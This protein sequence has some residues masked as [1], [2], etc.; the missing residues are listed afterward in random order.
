MVDA[1]VPRR[2]FVSY[3]RADAEVAT[4]IAAGLRRAGH[5]VTI[6]A[7]DF[8]PGNNFVI[9]MQQGLTTADHVL[10]VLSPAYEQSPFATAEW[11]AAFAADPLG[12]ERRLIGVRVEDYQPAGLL[13]PIIY[14]DIVGRSNDEADALITAAIAS[15]QP[16][17]P[18]TVPLTGSVRASQV[19]GAPSVVPHFSGRRDALAAISVGLADGGRL[20]VTG[21]GGIGKTSLVST[22]VHE[23]HTDFDLVLWLYAPNR[24]RALEAVAVVVREL[25]LVDDHVDPELAEAALRGHLAGV[26]RALVVLDDCRDAETASSLILDADSNVLVTSRDDRG[27]R[28]AG[29]AQHRLDV[30]DRNEAIE[31]V[32][33][34]APEGG[35]GADLVVDALEGL[36]LALA[37]A[38]AY[39]DRDAISFTDFMDRLA[40]YAPQVFEQPPG[41]HYT[42][43]VLSTWSL[44]LDDLQSADPAAA[45]ILNLLAFVDP[46]DFP[47]GVLVAGADALP[48]TIAAVARD[49]FM[50]D[51][52]IALLLRQSLCR[53]DGDGLSVHPVIQ[54]VVKSRLTESETEL[55]IRSA[56]VMLRRS[57]PEDDDAETWSTWERLAAHTVVA[58][59]DLAARGIYSPDFVPLVV[60]VA[61]FSSRRGFPHYANYL[62][63]QAIGYVTAHADQAVGSDALFVMEELAHSF[64][65]LRAADR[66]VSLLRSLIEFSQQHGQQVS[67]GAI[68]ARVGLASALTDTGD[69][70]EALRE[71]ELAAQAF[72]EW[73]EPDLSLGGRLY[74]TWGRLLVRTGS[75]AEG[76]DRLQR[77][78]LLAEEAGSDDDLALTHLH[79]GNSYRGVAGCADARRHYECARDIAMQLPDRPQLHA[80]IL[81]NLSGVAFESGDRSLALEHTETALRILGDVPEGLYSVTAAMIRYQR[82]QFRA[83]MPGVSVMEVLA[84]AGLAFDI[85][86][87]H[88]PAG[89]P[90]RHQIGGFLLSIA[91]ALDDDSIRELVWER[92]PGLRAE[93]GP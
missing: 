66:A 14:V 76:R 5:E 2:L 50:L 93:P 16:T 90:H 52:A 3:T 69:H 30:L 45:W 60:D 21:F 46:N 71:L 36:P 48:E 12:T 72:E 25:G 92:E 34:A 89:H 32:L 10:A 24:Q 91:E 51:A 13:G 42:H 81:V 83:R 53:A 64:L 31:F 7:A 27:W 17:T 49:P 33:S 11:A 4:R 61:R 79:L 39:V 62:Y 57:L 35:D 1:P 68:A 20:A 84:D 28:P 82:A 88:L 44:A 41:H 87:D 73:A 55:T 40:T 67:R 63:T 19:R 56:V 26:G 18:V 8:R 38:A 29:F 43:T 65:E 75:P 37:Q 6:Q 23:H 77:A 9:E 58:A 70:A 15:G 47:R 59:A 80:E 22:W 85:A 54:G 86:C 74:G 78:L